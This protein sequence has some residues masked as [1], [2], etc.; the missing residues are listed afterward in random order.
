MYTLTVNGT[1][2]QTELK[3]IG[4]A[5]LVYLADVEM[6][7][8]SVPV[9]RIDE[10]GASHKVRSYDIICLHSDKSSIFTVKKEG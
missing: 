5:V 1:E 7:S 4:M 9:Y 8:S 6:T 10:Q 2:H 3:F